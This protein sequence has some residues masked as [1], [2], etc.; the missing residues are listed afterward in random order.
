[1]LKFIFIF[2]LVNYFLYSTVLEETNNSS[3]GNINKISVSPNSKL[4][5]INDIGNKQIKLYNIETGLLIDLIEINNFYTDAIYFYLKNKNRETT[6]FNILNENV[7]LISAKEYFINEKEIYSYS[8]NMSVAFSNDT[9][10][11]FTVNVGSLCLKESEG[12]IRKMITPISTIFKYNLN[13]KIV[14]LFAYTNAYFNKNSF[15]NVHSNGLVCNKNKNYIESINTKIYSKKYDNDTKNYPIISEVI[16]DTA[17]K[18]IIFLPKEYINTGLNYGFSN[19]RFDIADNQKIYHT[20]ALL[21][22]VYLNNKKYFEIYI[23]SENDKI[24][25]NDVFQYEQFDTDEIE[26]FLDDIFVKNNYIYTVLKTSVDF[27]EKKYSQKTYIQ[28]YSID[29]KDLIDQIEFNNSEIK[30]I[31][32]DKNKNR[33]VYIFLNKN[34]EYEIGYINF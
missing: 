29:T 3:I 33:F 32:F 15:A 5:A 10:V 14:D 17:L 9:T 25:L 8:T 12:E 24:K 11:L 31:Y 18:P 6:Y 1:M 27:K 21:P 2:F 7:T 30:Q 22:Y 13:S 28:K 34:E 19:I 20:F 16:S 23:K 26:F 4:L